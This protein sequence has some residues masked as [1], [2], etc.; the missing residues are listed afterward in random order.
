VSVV[1]PCHNEEGNLRKL[2][3]ELR[4][5]LDQH[6]V[7]YEIV[8]TDDGS[9]DGSWS[10]LRELASQDP[11]MRVQ[12]LARNCGESTASWAGMRTAKGSYIITID[13]DLQND[14][15]DIPRFLEAMKRF[16]CVCGTR[17]SARRIGDSLI[18]RISSSIAN[19]VRNRVTKEH[20][21]DS[22]CT[23][24][25]FRRECLD[26]IRPFEG[27]HRFLPSLI[28]MNGFTLTE[29]EV[30]CRPR[31]AGSAHYGVLNRVFAATLDLMAVRW[32]KAR[33]IRYEVAERLGYQEQVERV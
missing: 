16:D 11:R 12:R 2:Y 6:E 3:H 4:E 18:R 8:I 29:I 13:A 26:D 33:M 19:S 25:A 10:V 1:I 22:G 5:V 32:M 20:I 9:S 31:V 23:Y 14:P 21:T 15:H 28:G 30:A 24:R 7:S 27:M 17:V